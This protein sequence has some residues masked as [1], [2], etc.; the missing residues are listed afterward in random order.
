MEKFFQSILIVVAI[1]NAIPA[2]ALV[3]PN[4]LSHFYGVNALGSEL[5]LLL[6]HRAV[7]FGILGGTIAYCAL[8]PSLFQLG[9]IIA[10]VSMGSF[11]CLAWPI[12]GLDAKLLKVF[13]IDVG[14]ILVLVAGYLLWRLYGISAR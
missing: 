12:A 13:W 10:L 3:I 9:F 5:E 7:M 8:K 14:A 6:K 1:I 11:V 2:L 4:G